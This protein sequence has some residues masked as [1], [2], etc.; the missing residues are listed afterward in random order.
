MTL[1]LSV[2]MHKTKAVIYSEAPHWLY[3]E[4]G[5]D[6]EMKRR[7]ELN[8]KPKVLRQAQGETK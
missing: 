6:E 2:R 4:P 3:T 5:L 1:L 7:L 8:D